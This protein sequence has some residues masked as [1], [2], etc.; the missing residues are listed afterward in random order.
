MTNLINVGQTMTSMQ[1]AEVT[2]KQH[3]DV[4][5]AIRNMEPAW[6][7]ITASKFTLRY[8]INELANGVKKETPYYE[9][10]KT[11][12]LYIA[13]KF[14]DE[15]RARLILRWEQLENGRFTAPQPPQAV[16]ALPPP[17]ENQ[18]VTLP[19]IECID[20]KVVTT[21]RKLAEVLGRKHDSI[22]GTIK[23][24]LHQRAFKYGNFTTRPYSTG[25]AHGYEFLITRK[26]LNALAAVMRYN[27]KSRI[28]EAYDGAWD[29]DKKLLPAP[30]PVAPAV[31]EADREDDRDTIRELAKW[32]DELRTELRKTRETMR[33]YAGM[34]EN[35]KK[36]RLR[37]G[38]M[39]GYW[40]DLY[41]DLIWRVVEGTAGTLDERLAAHRAFRDRIMVK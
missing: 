34:Y 7:K 15:A 38:D 5:R 40:H 29:G 2:G 25:A 24:N 39:S 9:L 16:G 27:A 31:P 13:T 32:I 22:L 20:G 17:A 3:C 12:C 4:L 1:I 14:N 6:E 33:M 41:E 11:E 26:G 8:K 10:T 23:S 28:A 19:Y 37:N 36:R 30:V 35:E 18:E 21:S